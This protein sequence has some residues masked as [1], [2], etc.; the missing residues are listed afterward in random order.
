[1][2]DMLINTANYENKPTKTANVGYVN[3][4]GKL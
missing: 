2:W 4:Y 1:M 3:K